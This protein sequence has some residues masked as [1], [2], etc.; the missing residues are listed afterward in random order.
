MRNFTR[1]RVA[2]AAPVCKS[3]NVNGRRT[4][5]PG[6]T[7]APQNAGVRFFRLLSQLH[8]LQPGVRSEVT[9]AMGVSSRRRIAGPAI[10][11]LFTLI[12]V[13][14]VPAAYAAQAGPSISG[15]SSSPDEVRARLATL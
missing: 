14:V 2:W 10:F 3:L 5:V 15:A 8:P 1:R 9:T 13:L 11:F 7:L 4:I 6:T 12:P